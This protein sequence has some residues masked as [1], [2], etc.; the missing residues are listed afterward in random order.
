MRLPL[1]A[2]RLAARRRPPVRRALLAPALV[3]LALLAPLA[4]AAPVAAAAAP[5]KVSSACNRSPFGLFCPFT[6][7]NTW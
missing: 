5:T 4:D 3:L 1:P 7:P 2:H 6:R